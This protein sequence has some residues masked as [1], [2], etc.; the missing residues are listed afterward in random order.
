VAAAL[1]PDVARLFWDTD[2]ERVDLR[3]HRDYVLERVMSRGSW[4]AM[5]WLRSTYSAEDIAD[6]LVRKGRRL[7]PRE[8]A[9]WSLIA[10][11]EFTPARG[12]GRPPWAG[13]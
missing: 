12:G 8:L 10:G 6:F 1:P 3:A 9:Y 5:C 7:A 2:P 11:V 13:P 4:T